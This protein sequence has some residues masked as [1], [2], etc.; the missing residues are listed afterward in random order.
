HRAD[1]KGTGGDPGNHIHGSN[2]LLQSP[3]RATEQFLLHV[4]AETAAHFLVI[5]D[6]QYQQGAETTAGFD[7]LQRIGQAL[8]QV[9]A[10]AQGGEAVDQ[11]VLFKQGVVAGQQLVFFQQAVDQLT[12]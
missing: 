3:G 4:L 8:Q 7:P 9:A 1:G 10:V 2:Q 5:L 6:A 11:V 12:D